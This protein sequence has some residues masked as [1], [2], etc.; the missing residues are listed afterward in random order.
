MPL[1]AF[2]ANAM[3]DDIVR[4]M[5]AGFDRYLTKPVPLDSLYSCLDE[6]LAPTPTPT[7]G[8]AAPTTVATLPP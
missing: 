2:S 8:A 5:A 6:L 7:P 3:P 4:S 1:V